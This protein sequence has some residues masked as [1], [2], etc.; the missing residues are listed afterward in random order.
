MVAQKRANLFF[1]W[2]CLT[3]DVQRSIAKTRTQQSKVKRKKSSCTSCLLRQKDGNAPPK[4]TAAVQAKK[5]DR[6]TNPCLGT[7]AVLLA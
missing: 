2:L 5:H 6:K 4:K 1:F 7:A 3:R